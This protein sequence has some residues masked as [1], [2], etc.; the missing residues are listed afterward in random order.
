MTTFKRFRNTLK[1]SAKK[2]QT[3]SCERKKKLRA[4]SRCTMATI[5]RRNSPSCRC[6]LKSK[7]QPRKRK[8]EKPSL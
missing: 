1:K 4:S 3:L 8:R 7:Q 6:Y 2:L 5:A